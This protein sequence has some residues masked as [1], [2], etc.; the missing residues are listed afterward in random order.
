[1][2]G[3][4]WR[5]V[6]GCDGSVLITSTAGNTAERDAPDNLSLAFEGFETVRSAKA[7]VEAACPDQVSCTDVL[8]IATRDAIALVRYALHQLAHA[9]EV[10]GDAK[11][12]KIRAERWAILPGGAGQAGRHEV[13]RQQ[14]RRQAAAAEQHP[15][16]ARR[17]L[18]IQRPQHV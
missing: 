3:V 5:G 4:A 10:T 7:A 6:Q 15:Q 18:Q 17:H 12:C 16:R 2:C 9:L 11:H 14:R 8:A 1:M 13:Q